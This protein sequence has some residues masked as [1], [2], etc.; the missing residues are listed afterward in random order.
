MKKQLL[1]TVAL[2][3]GLLLGGAPA[4]AAILE[5]DTDGAIPPSGPN[6]AVGSFH[7]VIDQSSANTFRVLSIRANAGPPIPNSNTEHV[8][9]SFLNS[10]GDQLPVTGNT[11]GGVNGGGDD[12]G[13]GTILDS[14]LTHNVTWNRPMA[15]DKLLMD[16]SNRFANSGFVTVSGAPVFISI[17]IANGARSWSAGVP[18]GSAVPE[19]ASLALV[20]PGLVPLAM[21]LRRRRKRSAVEEEAT[22]TS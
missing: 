11:L 16:G 3:A 12:W 2:L 9:L 22:S 13:S 6:Q 19:P 7:V 10:A 17:L 20:L 18:V 5:V 8:S 14:G 1:A 15:G 4:H 21:T